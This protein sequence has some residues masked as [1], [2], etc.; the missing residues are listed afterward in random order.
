MRL[1]TLSDTVRFHI[2]RG[3]MLIHGRESSHAKLFRVLELSSSGRHA[4]LGQRELVEI[5]H[6]LL[7]GV[8]YWYRKNLYPQEAS[9]SQS[10]PMLSL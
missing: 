6:S 3:A 1:I 2:E 7:S 8:L 10:P 5:I 4:Q 9:E